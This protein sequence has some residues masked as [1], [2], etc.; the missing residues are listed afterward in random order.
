[1]RLFICRNCLIVLIFKKNLRKFL[2][3]LIIVFRF[4]IFYFFDFGIDF[5]KFSFY[6]NFLYGYIYCLYWD[7]RFWV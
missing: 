4:F 2:F 6:L 7:G 3:W 5:F 1:M